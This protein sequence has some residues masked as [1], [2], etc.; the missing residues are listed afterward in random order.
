MEEFR[1]FLAVQG[2]GLAVNKDV[3]RIFYGRAS[4]PAARICVRNN[5]VGESVE[6]G[7]VIAKSMKASRCGAIA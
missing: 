4:M 2:V 1:D 3:V 5:S 7:V 6:M